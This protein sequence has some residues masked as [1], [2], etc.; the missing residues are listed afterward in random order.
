MRRQTGKVWKPPT[1]PDYHPAQEPLIANQKVMISGLIHFSA[2][3]TP[4]FA[5]LVGF[6]LYN[7]LTVTIHNAARPAMAQLLAYEEKLPA[8]EA[9]RAQRGRARLL[10]VFGHLTCW[11]G[12][13]QAFAFLQAN[14]WSIHGDSHWWLEMAKFGGMFVAGLIFLRLARKF[15]RRAAPVPNPRRAADVRPQGNCRKQP[16]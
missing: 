5:P 9:V 3:W 12:L 6:P 11:W 15:Q 2:E 10:R 1:L 8:S 16:P 4:T 13:V 14:E 7:V